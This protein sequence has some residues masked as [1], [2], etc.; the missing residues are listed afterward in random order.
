V[1]TITESD[2]RDV[3]GGGAASAAGGES[4]GGMTIRLTSP[5]DNRVFRL[6]PRLPPEAQRIAVTAVPGVEL[7]AY[8]PPVTL[9]LDGARFASPEGPDY[10]SWWQLQAGRHTFHAVAIRPDGQ[11]VSSDSVTVQVQ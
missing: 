4:I 8:N 1:E 3:V 2:R 6:D 10:T 11:I 7:A 5:D 9:Y